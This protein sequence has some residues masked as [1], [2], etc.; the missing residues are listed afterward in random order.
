MNLIP[1]TIDFGEG[2]RD[3]ARGQ[4][5]DAGARGAGPRRARSPPLVARIRKAAGHVR[6]AAC[7]LFV[8]RAS[9]GT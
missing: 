7:P 1:I 6:V 9:I 4:T 5:A 8:T 3:V 2:C